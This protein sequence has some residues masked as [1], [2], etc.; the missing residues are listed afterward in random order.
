MSNIG[1]FTKQDDGF[2]GTLRTLTINVKAKFVGMGN[3]LQ[4]LRRDA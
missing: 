2:V 3:R 4:C 1:T